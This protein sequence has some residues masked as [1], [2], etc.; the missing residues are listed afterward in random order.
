VTGQVGAITESGDQ[1][2]PGNAGVGQGLCRGETLG[3]EDEEG[4]F[5][6][7]FVQDGGELRLV[8]IGGEREL[9]LLGQ[10]GGKGFVEQ[11]WPEI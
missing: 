3:C 11:A 9:E 1:P 2:V 10:G 6:L 5:R 8:D 4:F 7:G